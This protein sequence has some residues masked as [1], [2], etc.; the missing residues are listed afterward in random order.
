M[1]LAPTPPVPKREKERIKYTAQPTSN[2][3]KTLKDLICY[4]EEELLGI[5]R[6]LHSSLP[7]KLRKAMWPQPGVPAC[8]PA[9]LPF[10][11]PPPPLLRRASSSLSPSLFPPHSSLSIESLGRRRRHSARS[12]RS[13]DSLLPAVASALVRIDR[14]SRYM[15]DHFGVPIIN[16]WCDKVI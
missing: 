11:S 13:I 5:L 8:L 7:L 12:P 15:L 4:I 10:G 6:I 1:Q 3:Q 16:V 14:K 2:R 9:C